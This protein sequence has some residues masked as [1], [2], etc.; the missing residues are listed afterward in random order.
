MA[1]GRLSIEIQLMAA[2]GSVFIPVESCTVVVRRAATSD[3][4]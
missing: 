4:T 1:Y 2:T 3:Y